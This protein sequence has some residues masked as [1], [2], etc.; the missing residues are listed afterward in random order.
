MCVCGCVGGGGF[1]SLGAKQLRAQVPIVLR[2]GVGMVSS[3]AE[4]EWRVREGLY[5][6]RRLQ[7]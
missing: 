5:S 1:H 6:W 2:R 4:V 7:R 3:P